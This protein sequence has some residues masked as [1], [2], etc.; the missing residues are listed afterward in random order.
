MVVPDPRWMA[1]HKLWLSDKPERNLLKKD[2][3]R[4]QGNVL[5]DAVRFFLPT[6]HP[7][8]VDFVLDLPAELQ[9]LFDRWCTET[10]FIPSP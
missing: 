9:P 2:K 8:N 5:L 6:S 3:D 4:R 10:G 1:L 7:I